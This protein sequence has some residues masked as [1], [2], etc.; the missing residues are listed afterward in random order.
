MTFPRDALSAGGIYDDTIG[1]HCT[2]DKGEKVA[3]SIE[4]RAATP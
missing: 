4:V 3:K 1:G 2:G